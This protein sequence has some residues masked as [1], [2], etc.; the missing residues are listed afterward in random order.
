M[1][2]VKTSYRLSI[3]Y[4]V[5]PGEPTL[6]TAC[7]NRTLGGL[8]LQGL[9]IND[10][11]D[12]L[13]KWENVGDAF[14][15]SFSEE[16]DVTL[17]IYTNSGSNLT[18][19]K[20]GFLQELLKV[21]SQTDPQGNTVYPVTG[22]SLPSWDFSSVTRVGS[23]FMYMFF[24]SSTYIPQ[25]IATPTVTFSF[26]H[27]ETIG[28]NFMNQAFR[29]TMPQGTSFLPSITFGALKSV[30]SYFMFQYLLS[31][32]FYNDDATY[33]LYNFSTLESVGD[34]FM[35]E[36]SPRFTRSIVFP[37]Y[38]FH[39]LR[40]IGS[41]FMTNA[42]YM[43]D[44]TVPAWDMSGYTEA[45]VPSNFMKLGSNGRKGTTVTTPAKTPEPAKSW[46]NLTAAAYTFANPLSWVAPSTMVAAKTAT[47]LTTLPYYTEN[48]IKV[49]CYTG[50]TAIT[51]VPAS[52]NRSYGGLTC[53]AVWDGVLLSSPASTAAISV[54]PANAG[55]H[56]LYL[57]FEGDP[58]TVTNQ[59]YLFYQQFYNA[60]NQ[61]FI[62]G[63][64]WH[65]NFT[66][67]LSGNYFMYQ[68]LVGALAIRWIKFPE[69][70]RVV[71]THFMA[72]AFRMNSAIENS[73]SE[74]TLRHVKFPRFIFSTS[75]PDYFLY[76]TFSGR[77]FLNQVTF[78]DWY[79]SSVTSIGSHVLDQTFCNYNNT[80]HTTYVVPAGSTYRNLSKATLPNCDLSHVTSI[81][82]YFLYYTYCTSSTAQ[83]N[84]WVT[85][86]NQGKLQDWPLPDWDFSALQTVGS[87][88]FSF[89][90]SANY[91]KAATIPASQEGADC[92]SLPEYTF[93][94]L[95]SVGDY[96]FRCFNYGSC[97]DVY[98]KI[99]VPLYN[100]STLE[101][102]GKSFMAAN[103]AFADTYDI[104]CPD[105]DFS[106]LTTIGDQF[107]AYL[108]E[109]IS[110]TLTLPAWNMHQ[111]ASVPTQFFWCAFAGYP[112]RPVIRVKTPAKT[113]APAYSWYN[114]C[115]LYSA[116]NSYDV[117]CSKG[118][119]WETTTAFGQ[120]YQ[121]ILKGLTYLTTTDYCITAQFD[122]LT[123][124]TS[125]T[126]V[127]SNTYRT[128]PMG[129][130]AVYIDT[131]AIAWA[132][133]T[134]AITKTAT[135]TTH[136]LR[137]YTGSGASVTDLGGEV[138]ANSPLHSLFASSL[139]TK[140][141]FPLWDFSNVVTLKNF[142]CSTFNGCSKLEYV[143]IPDYDFSNVTN[144][145]LTTVYHQG[146]FSYTFYGCSHLTNAGL[147]WS[148][149]LSLPK[150]V[151]NPY[152]SFQDVFYNCTNLTACPPVSLILP[153]AT[154][155]NDYAFS[156]IY[157]GCT[158]LTTLVLPHLHAPS[159]TSI[160][161][162]FCGYVFAY[163]SNATSVNLEVYDF[164]KVTSIGNN[165][166]KEAF[167]NCTS[168][169][170]V[171]LPLWDFSNVTS[172]GSYFLQWCFEDCTSL[173]DS[174]EQ[175]DW[176][177]PYTLQAW[178]FSKVTS[179]GSSFLYGF[180]ETCTN[181]KHVNLPYWNF[182]S[183]TSIGSGFLYYFWGDS[184][185]TDTAGVC[186]TIPN[187]N[188]SNVTSV[189]TNFM[190]S[191]WAST[192]HGLS[193][194]VPPMKFTGQPNYYEKSWHSAA[195]TL[196][197]LNQLTG[198]FSVASWLN[199]PTD[200]NWSSSSN[201]SAWN[202]TAMNLGRGIQNLD[203]G[204]LAPQHPHITMKM[205]WSTGTS[206][207][208]VWG[209]NANCTTGGLTCLQKNADGMPWG[210]NVNTTYSWSGRFIHQ[211]YHLLV[212]YFLPTTT[213]S[214]TAATYSFYGI[215]AQQVTLAVKEAYRILE[216]EVFPS[217]KDDMFGS[218]ELTPYNGGGHVTLGNYFL[219]NA[220][221][222]CKYLKRLAIGK[223]FKNNGS[224]LT[225]MGDFCSYLAHQKDNNDSSLYHTLS[226]VSIPGIGHQAPWD[227]SKV[228]TIGNLFT[229]AFQG[230]ALR[231]YI[232]PN[233]TFTKLQTTTGFFDNT[234]QDNSGIGD[235]VVPDFNFTSLTTIGQFFFD[236][237]FRSSGVSRAV[238]PKFNLSTVTTIGTTFFREIFYGCT[239]LYELCIP[240]WDM[241]SV[242][243]VTTASYF[244]DAFAHTPS[245]IIVN[246]TDDSI[247]VP[248][249]NQFN[250]ADKVITIGGIATNAPYEMKWYTSERIGTEW[251]RIWTNLVYSIPTLTIKRRK[252]GADDIPIT[253]RG[254]YLDSNYDSYQPYLPGIG[255]DYIEW[256]YTEGGIARTYSGRYL[257]VKEPQTVTLNHYKLDG[258]GARTLYA[259]TTYDVPA[260]PSKPELV[261]TKGTESENGC[262][263]VIKTVNQE[264]FIGTSRY[265]VY[266][267]S[268][269]WSSANSEFTAYHSGVYEAILID[270]Y[271]WFEEDGTPS[272]I[273]SVTFAVENPDHELIIDTEGHDCTIDAYAKPGSQ[274]N[275]IKFVLD[276]THKYDIPYTKVYGD[277][278]ITLTIEE[279]H[280]PSFLITYN[281]L[282]SG[283]ALS[284]N[285]HGSTVAKIKD[286]I[287]K[288]K[289]NG[290]VVAD[291][292][293]N[294]LIWLF[295]NRTWNDA[296]LLEITIDDSTFSTKTD[297]D[298]FFDYLFFGVSNLRSLYL[299]YFDTH[300]GTTF[301][302]WLA[303]LA[304][305]TSITELYIPAYDHSA[306]LNMQYAY[307][308]FIT[309]TPIA[310]Y[311]LFPINCKNATN[312]SQLF[313]SNYYGDKNLKSVVLPLVDTTS[314]TN[315][316]GMLNLMTDSPQTWGYPYWEDLTMP[317]YDLSN[318]TINNLTNLGLNT[319]LKTIY[320]PTVSTTATKSW[321][322]AT[323]VFAH[324][325]T[326]THDGDYLTLANTATISA[327][328]GT[329]TYVPA[330]S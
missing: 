185:A 103:F 44:F 147:H 115:G 309:R 176:F 122:N 87:N 38:D 21:V 143:N 322:N 25:F 200:W 133:V 142:F 35:C 102:V 104:V 218:T 18:V 246:T 184:G 194:F 217:G 268:S 59:N 238:F 10:T 131:T 89:T 208:T 46:Y 77:Q 167:W 28:D 247:A 55:Y 64:D 289:Y 305:D 62:Y 157:R 58:A 88:C 137:I 161:T 329:V 275:P 22:V 271:E 174:E 287:T 264:N 17:D 298:S 301:V 124:G 14:K 100:F 216:L 9:Y 235:V 293:G 43:S 29:H 193:V 181:L 259:S 146:Y 159:A 250:A 99:I 57:F 204:Y 40:S 257:T 286:Y 108:A 53:R 136:V 30:G 117:N 214:A 319:N 105:Y 239:N 326:I 150:A 291:S 297:F 179:L 269:G 327:A 152:A 274:C 295:A 52:A 27:L 140:V 283:P 153:V 308:G 75:I 39:S 251:Q 281:A 278:P 3:S 219:G 41:N 112:G 323:I 68:A 42:Y 232:I 213:A 249:K 160:G 119:I 310:N 223:L 168:L 154:R 224:T 279:Q 315:A 50:T 260:I 70:M 313:Q 155:I 180:F 263:I 123:S 79:T 45:S 282:A 192:N 205:Y 328:E 33:P 15:Y 299:P 97:G 178:D 65:I 126:F 166:F 203:Y 132:N 317:L 266:L 199:L 195:G 31:N 284:T 98:G 252:N 202:T 91:P 109:N 272:V 177:S 324:S 127:P 183:L 304:N 302:R 211:G 13:D 306:A 51:I 234:Y 236:Q 226:K 7:S 86:N 288:V 67:L 37:D 280:R 320:A 201:P 129:I 32:N 300:S 56:T 276:P 149:T 312:I 61:S 172:I 82:D 4:H 241:S 261:L 164:S 198:V 116:Q 158:G 321:N 90:I 311:H 215:A 169:I 60:S 106:N 148:G 255:G 92:R 173:L 292:N 24:A 54:T 19:I 227:F 262:P 175:E 48:Y 47:N 191:F 76:R 73:G 258:A 182:S 165:F 101:S 118:A 190:K 135:D 114:V 294:A 145:A 8:D 285:A 151:T 134:S 318:A 121:K 20:S 81:G 72:E 171:K 231:D 245:G 277:T 228:T 225:S 265:Y 316:D 270:E 36:C 220:A 26:D 187:W 162:Q 253:Y 71:G 80:I 233:I 83:P 16:C 222:Y 206:A 1:S 49:Q 209:G 93:G 130:S 111:I 6:I 125:Y 120:A 267:R 197:A 78:S 244:Q 212:F 85:R 325:V 314:V 5:Y 84:A 113:P 94:S 186:V 156:Y 237:T 128:M 69:T 290:K 248:E 63:I 170:R 66:S 256:S 242:Q 221:S 330:L 243:T 96:F 188:F 230:A 12:V 144:S 74:T 110:G 210:T 107:F 189:G 207:T 95:R 2:S 240:I 254:Y 229:R 138:Q 23:N 163:C 196:T 303:N 11:I 141:S 296:D 273:S 307:G 34:Y 139:L